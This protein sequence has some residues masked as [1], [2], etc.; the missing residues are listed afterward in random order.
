MQEI[1]EIQE[2][3]YGATGEAAVQSGVSRKGQASKPPNFRGAS[4]PTFSWKEV[5]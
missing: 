4:V 1:Q 3:P 2:R 5:P